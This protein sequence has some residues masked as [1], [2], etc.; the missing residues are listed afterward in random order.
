MNYPEFFNRIETIKLNDPL[1]R[2]LGA[3]EDGIFEYSYQDIVKMAGH[4]CPT[5]AGAYLMCQEGLKALYKNEIPTRGEIFVS[6]KED[7]LEGVAGVIANVV[8]NITGATEKHGFKGMAGK[9]FTRT[10]LMEFNANISSSIKLTRTDTKKSIEVIYDPSS[11][12]A[13]DMLMPIMQLIL[14]GIV[15]EDEKLEF[16][17]IWQKRV[18]DIFSNINKVISVIQ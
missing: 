2:L 4:S 8:S 15:T 12:P 9:L 14:Q 10:G 18:E 7:N 16:G 5:V 3:S 6:F 1:S 11:I 13:G 17:K